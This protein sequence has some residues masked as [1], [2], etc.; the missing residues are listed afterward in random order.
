[1]GVVSKRELI[2]AYLKSDTIPAI[3]GTGHYNLSVETVTREF[4][5]LNELKGFQYPV[6]AIL[7]DA[8][9]NYTPLTAKEYTTGTSHQDL[10]NGMVVAI[11]GYVKVDRGAGADTSG[12][13]STEMNKIFSDIIIAMHNDITL[14]GNCLSVV[15]IST[16]HSVNYAE[17]YGVGQVACLFS[18]K[19]DFN[20]SATTTPVT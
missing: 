10:E 17:K 6:V 2:L 3:T 1:M 13:L 8:P 7:D 15:L 14:G 4:R 12:I 5:G 16:D 11:V 9:V 20:P 18:I 19:Y